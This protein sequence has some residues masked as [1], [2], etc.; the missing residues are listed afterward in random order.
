MTKSPNGVRYAALTGVPVRTKKAAQA[1]ADH[2]RALIGSGELVQGD[3]LPPEA[4]LLEQFHVSKPTLREAFRI[5]EAESLLETRQGAGGGVF[6]TRPDLTVASRHIGLYL[7]LSNTTIA[8]VFAA[9]ELV[10]P[11]AVRLLALSHTDKDI[12]DLRAAIDE[13]KAL[14]LTARPS[15]QAWSAASYRFHE[16]LWDR[17]GNNTVAAQISVLRELL[18]AQWDASI[19]YALNTSAHAQLLRQS[20]RSYSRAVDLIEAEDADGA[21]R[22]WRKHTRASTRKM[23]EATGGATV[24]PNG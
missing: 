3:A 7:Q 15:S 24:N 2:I 4:V 19:H 16:M 22:H 17:C 23:I 21:E 14:A 12:A 8:D 20:C 6:V 1:I 11:I 9:H 13:I 18:R 5:L 10:E